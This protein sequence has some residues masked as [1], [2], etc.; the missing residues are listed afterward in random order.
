MIDQK[1]T[2]TLQWQGPYAMFPNSDI[3]LIYDRHDAQGPGVYLWT[4]KSGNEYWVHYVGESKKVIK[5]QREHVIEY[6]GGGYWLYDPEQFAAGV[7]VPWYKST[8]NITTFLN[9]Y[10]I[11]SK[12]AVAM[13]SQFRIFYVS[14]ADTNLSTKRVEGGLIRALKD[15]NETS[16]FIDNDKIPPAFPE[17]EQMTVT[18]AGHERLRGIPSSLAI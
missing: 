1:S 13:I 16:S 3:E 6:L 18:F 4:I 14:L 8:E 10:E 2:I 7:L 9:Q 11:L 12:V 5:R 17:E 15:N